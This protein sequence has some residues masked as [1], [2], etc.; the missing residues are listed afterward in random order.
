[1]FC[2]EVV[3]SPEDLSP[4]NAQSGRVVYP[5]WLIALNISG[6]RPAF[7]TEHLLGLSTSSGLSMIS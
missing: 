4:K 3:L 7:R 5:G 6:G 1:M 2:Q